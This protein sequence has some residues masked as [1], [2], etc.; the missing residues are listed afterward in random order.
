MGNLIKK[1]MISVFVFILVVPIALAEVM[2]ADVVIIGAGTSG[3]SAALSALENGAKTILIEKG[4]FPAGAGTFSGGMFAAD[5]SQQKK[6]GKTVDKKKLIDRYMEQSNYHANARLVANIVNNA[7]RAVDFVNSNGAQ[8]KLVDPGT[9]GQYWH[10]GTEAV[11]HGYQNG[12]GSK[13]IGRLQDTFKK[14]GGTLLFETKATSLIKNADG[15]IAGV[16][17]E[18]ADGNELRLMASKAVIVATG[19][20]GA[21]A[22]MLKEF[23]N[24]PDLPLS[25]VNN[26]QGEGLAMAWAAGAKKGNVIMQNFATNPNNKI[27][28]PLGMSDET[29]TLCD[30][31]FLRVNILGKRFIREDRASDYAM[32][33]NA[34]FDQP[35]HVAW[36]IFDQTS[37]D[38]IKKSGFSAIINQYG[39]WKNSK[40]EFYEFNE[41]I[42]VS[43]RAKKWAT[44]TDL[45]KF[46]EDGIVGGSMVK[47]DT[48]E[49]LAAK[50][51]IDPAVLKA[52]V[53]RYNKFAKAGKDEDFYNDPR[54]MYPVVKGPFYAFSNISRSIGALGGIV[55]NENLQ[56]LGNDNKVIK[57]LYAVGN[58]ATGM[59]GNG[60][61]DIEGGTLGF[62]FT[63]GML[64]G[65]NAAKGLK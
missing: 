44:P 33:G 57:G 23:F 59:Y 50:M 56:V 43:E 39:E 4:A 35:Q 5:S 62:G 27:D 8:M 19:G 28:T 10:K 65:E 13:N 46:I 17:A 47:A 22:E 29:W 18:D 32:I 53:T 14:K 34:I 26:A 9:G 1:L 6:L 58:D 7:G 2:N 21:N 20:M 16:V 15:S 48:I 64:A 51:N 25:P 60:Y 31:P 41:R 45:T 52:E 55:V 40:Q 63:S 61:V 37:V 30:L 36:Q 24:Y 38:K 12:G 54:F 42:S 3:T 11:L 49:E